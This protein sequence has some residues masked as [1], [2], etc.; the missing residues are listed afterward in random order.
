[1]KKTGKAGRLLLAAILITGLTGCG[2]FGEFDAGGYTEAVLSQR[3]QGELQEISE[4]EE[5]KT[6]KE[7]KEEYKEGI[8][9]FVDNITYGMDMSVETYRE[10]TELC[11]KI[12]SAM[13]YNV[14]EAEKISRKE[15]HVPV[16]IQ[17][18]GVFAE[19]VKLLEESSGE[20]WEK[21]QNGEYK[22]TEEEIQQ[23][24][25]FDI[26]SQSYALLETAYEEISYGE[27][28]EVILKVKSEDGKKFS[29][30]EKEMSGLIE[31]ILGLDTIQD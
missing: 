29:I 23:Q 24:M 25:M 17:P 19:Y 6:K 16:E 20:I 5:E 14:G 2:I 7:L 18:A 28:E 1:M 12:F 3:L 31:K 4:F 22:G 21:T 27:T 15:F 10:Y 9:S 13:R 26:V 30:D 11:E 8:T